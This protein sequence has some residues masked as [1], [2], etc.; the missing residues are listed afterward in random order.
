[1]T[2]KRPLA[3]IFGC[4][5]VRLT[6]R[7]RAFF[8]DCDPLGF[9]LFQR[10]C[11]S[12]DQVRALNADLRDCV[13]RDAPILI[14]QEGGRVRRLKPPHW[15]DHPAARRIGRVAERSLDDAIRAAGLHGRLIA[16][17]AAPLGIDHD[18]A[19]SLDLGLASESDIVGDRA[20]S[21]D[22]A[23]VAALGGAACEGLL[24]GGV[25]PIVKH[26]PGHGRAQ[27]DSHKSLPVAA[28]D[29]DDLVATDFVPFRALADWPW[30][31]TCHLMFTDID[32]DRP[33]TLSPLVIERAIR[34]AIGFD[35]VLVSDD[36]SM[37]ALSGTLGKRAAGAVA[38]GCDIAL[39]C[40][41]VFGEMGDVAASVPILSD[42]AI[43]RLRRADAM[44]DPKPEKADAA[45][46]LAELEAIL[47]A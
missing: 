44:R 40:N 10:N 30:A 32:T 45:A 27:V 4:E 41:G 29:W 31:M 5:G 25:M 22:P 18:A 2:E 33:A 46:L 16:A 17:M 13:G 3:A 15:P 14:D 21:G 9:I 28:A 39:H 23:V 7:E 8:R 6:E 26:S 35:G 34:G 19:P 47:S 11:D 42:V 1:M 24:A 20:F 36:L 37:N 12:P 43:K 38:A